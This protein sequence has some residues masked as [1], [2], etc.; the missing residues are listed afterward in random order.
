MS[1]SYD[2]SSFGKGLSKMETEIA[3]E[4]GLN[5]VELIT[6]K[7]PVLHWQ[8]M[9]ISQ[10]KIYTHLSLSSSEALRKTTKEMGGS[11][12]TTLTV[13][14]SDNFRLLIIPKFML[15]IDQV[16]ANIASLLYD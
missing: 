6:K 5:S 10:L 2:A 3:V 8:D 11:E 9:A 13:T 7:S 15:Q 16:Y 1:G 12:R 14:G 4:I